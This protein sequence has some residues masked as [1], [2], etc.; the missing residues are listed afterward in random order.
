MLARWKACPAGDISCKLWLGLLV[1]IIVFSLNACATKHSVPPKVAPM[2]TENHRSTDDG[3]AATPRFPILSA[4]Q[5]SSL[6]NAYQVAFGECVRA[7]GF[8]YWP[9]PQQ[10]LTL[11]QLFP[12][13]INSV[14]W[15]RSHGFGN[16]DGSDSDAA[17]QT[18]RRDPNLQYYNSLSSPKQAALIRAENAGGPN[19]PG[20]IARL[21]TGQAIGFSKYSCYAYAGNALYGTRYNWYQAEMTY[22]ALPSLWEE[23]VEGDPQYGHVLKAWAQCMKKKG[24]DYTTP[25]SA[26]NAFTAPTGHLSPSKS[27][28]AF[29]VAVDE[30]MCANST[31]Q[32]SAARELEAK[33][34]K[35]VVERYQSTVELYLQLVTAALPRAEKIVHSE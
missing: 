10:P 23:K 2:A 22:Y 32:A 14:S 3:G 8:R 31:N 34:K 5:Q 1:F 24:D 20:V 7:R 29:R 27:R 4:Q 25:S 19:D 15:A 18:N 6:F 16:P 9:E 35:L 11:S 28:T 30:A 33:Y 13:G 26:A 17:S 12:Y 21:P